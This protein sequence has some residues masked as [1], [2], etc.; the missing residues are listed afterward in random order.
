MQELWSNLAIAS[1]GIVVNTGGKC[2]VLMQQ[3][4]IKEEYSNFIKLYE[5]QFEEYFPASF[6]SDKTLERK[7]FALPRV[8]SRK[9]AEQGKQ[10]NPYWDGESLLRKYNETIKRVVLR[11]Y[12]EVFNRLWPLG[13]CGSGKQLEDQ[14][15]EFRQEF[16]KTHGRGR[17]PINKNCGAD[18]EYEQ[19]SIADDNS[20]A[21]NSREMPSDYFPPCWLVFV[22]FGKLSRDP[23][24]LFEGLKSDN[25]KPL[26]T[27]VPTRSEIRAGGETD[28][29]DHVDSRLGPGSKRKHEAT[30]A[31]TGM[32]AVMS[33]ISN[34]M[35]KMRKVDEE[36][37]AIKK[38]EFEIKC[39]ED[40][41]KD[42]IS[43]NLDQEAIKELRAELK[44]LRRQSI[45]PSSSA[46]P[47][48]ANVNC[49]SVIVETPPEQMMGIALL[50]DTDV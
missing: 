6:V 11:D 9:F 49:S 50:R 4:R 24:P 20:L 47:V 16:W 43:E 25:T 10:K 39:K 30:A 13:R 38:R 34:E 33:S 22:A 19:V 29:R 21:A 23:H 17:L 41:I 46:T 42:A 31:A 14:A 1:A 45:F 32:V 18:S 40:E 28:R 48:T 44:V 37:M 36:A 12:E 35:N 8:S 15:L 3:T 2:S 27:T 7:T 26:H 5:K